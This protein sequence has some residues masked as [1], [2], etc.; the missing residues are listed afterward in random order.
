[1]TPPRMEG[2]SDPAHS[3]RELVRWACG[4]DLAGIPREVLMRS[5]RILAD[6][7]AAIIAAREEREIT[8]LHTHLLESGSARESTIFRGGRPQTDRLRAALGNSVAACWLELDEGYRKAGCHAGLFILPALLAEAEAEGLAIGEVLRCLVVAYEVV[9]RIA[10][11]WILDKHPIHGHARYASLGAAAGLAV[12]RGLPPEEFL[13]ALSGAATFGF[14]G[15]HAYGH[16]GSLIRNAWPA[17]GAAT[18][19]FCISLA[20]AGIG[21]LPSSFDDVYGSLLGG[22]RAPEQM[23]RELSLSWA[24][25]DGDSKIHACCQ[26]GH[27][28]VEAALGVRQQLS[29]A[30]EITGIGVWTHELALGMR[31]AEPRNV[32]AG[33]FSLPHIVATSLVHGHAGL[34]AFG[35]AALTDRR[36][37][38]LRDIVRL[39]PWEGDLTPPRDRPARVQVRLSSGRVIESECLSATGGRDNPYTD[40]TIMH[41]IAQLTSPVYPG[42]PSCAARL[43]ECDP[44]LLEMPWPDFIGHFDSL[45]I[46]TSS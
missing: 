31:D 38:A 40:E 43:A 45:P 34:E 26:Y 29:A 28:S 7:L 41:K 32:L 44:Q 18:G 2:Q 8:D 16:K 33:K 42:F 11:T 46:T 39:A 4:V 21:G 3:S 25:M 13:S 10:R 20:R 5:G 6:D 12:A 22:A 23:T 36:V 24:V 37:A 35:A 17:V 9:T 19:F 27:A 1:M 14:T 30:D 15:P